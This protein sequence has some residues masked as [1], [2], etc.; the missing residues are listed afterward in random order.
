MRVLGLGSRVW[1]GFF[2]LGMIRYSSSGLF[3]APQGIFYDVVLPAVRYSCFYIHIYTHAKVEPYCMLFLGGGR[4][5]TLTAKH[6]RIE[7]QV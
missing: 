7:L 4:Y 1:D 2:G 6:H 5:P 3:A